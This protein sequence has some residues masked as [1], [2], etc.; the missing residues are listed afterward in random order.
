LDETPAFMLEDGHR[1]CA[2][3]AAGPAADREQDVGTERQADAEQS[4]DDWP[5]QVD[6]GRDAVA[7]ECMSG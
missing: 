3:L 4:L 6:D 5:E 2:R 7:R 1:E